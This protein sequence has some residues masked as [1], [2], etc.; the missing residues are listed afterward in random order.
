MP[1]DGDVL[2]L[3]DVRLSV[4]ALGDRKQGFLFPIKPIRRTFVREELKSARP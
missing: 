1:L 4:E 2:Q 3:D